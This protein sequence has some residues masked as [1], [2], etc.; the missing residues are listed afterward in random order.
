ME[1]RRA[2]SKNRV[3]AATTGWH[4]DEGRCEEQANFGGITQAIHK[5]GTCGVGR[6][7]LVVYKN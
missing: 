7:Y 4:Y 6:S 3:F 5:F 1:E 2:E